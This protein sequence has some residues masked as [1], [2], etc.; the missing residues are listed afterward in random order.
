MGLLMEIP[1]SDQWRRGEGKHDSSKH[2]MHKGPGER[3]KSGFGGSDVG[4]E[5][6]QQQGKEPGLAGWAGIKTKE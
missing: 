3:S 5:K 4:P 6:P 1:V 2:C